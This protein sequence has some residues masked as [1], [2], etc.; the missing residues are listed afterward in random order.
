MVQEKIEALID[1]KFQEPEFAD[2]FL[3]EIKLHSS[4]KLDVFIDSDSGI[5]FAKCRRIS[6]YL[7][8]YLDEHQWLGEKYV[9]EVSSPG[10][11]R[12]L[13]LLRQY[14]KNIG[15]KVEVSLQEGKPKEG[16]LKAVNETG[17][18]LEEKVRVQE[19][20]RKKTLVQ[21]TEIPFEDIVKTI[22]KVSF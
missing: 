13:R 11:D 19:G 12:P 18:F 8:Q 6:R 22:V 4:N 1:E 2:C 9:L 20:K 16:I 21:E 5:T 10:V 17:L 14:K 7:E 15:R 3:I